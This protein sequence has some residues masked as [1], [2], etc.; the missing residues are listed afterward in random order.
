MLRKNALAKPSKC[1]LIRNAQVR[2]IYD[3]M[4]Q[5]VFPSHIQSLT[6]FCLRFTSDEHAIRT[7][8]E[9]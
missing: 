2:L 4:I 3:K 1:S 8:E 5:K 9:L 6:N 7:E